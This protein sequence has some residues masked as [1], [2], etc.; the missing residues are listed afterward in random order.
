MLTNVDIEARKAAGRKAA[1]DEGA[2]EHKPLGDT[3]PEQYPYT[4]WFVIGYNEAVD[5][6]Q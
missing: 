3:S 1:Q 6:A 5:E 4:Y 2:T